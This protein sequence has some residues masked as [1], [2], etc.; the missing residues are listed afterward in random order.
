MKITITTKNLSIGY[1]KETIMSG[2]NCEL[3][4]G[5]MTCLIGSNGVGK[6]TLLR[7]LAGFQPP[8]DGEISILDRKISD[9]SSEELSKTI[10]IVLTDKPDIKEMTVEEIVSMGRTPYTN[11]WGTISHEDA[12][13]IENSMAEIGITDL[14]KK[15][16]SKLSDGEK[17]KTMIAKTIAQQTPIILLDEPTAFLD[18]PS[19]IETMKLLKTLAHNDNKTILLSTHDL[20]LALQI[21]DKLWLMIDNKIYTGTPQELMHNGLLPKYLQTNPKMK[22]SPHNSADK[23]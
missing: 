22:I 23:S 17:Q 19:K 11:F 1:R 4:S 18:Y 12:Q 14:R 3:H 7:T 8:I 21:T 10:G 16:F 2:I 9:F 13:I 20:E 15:H 5:E 6:S